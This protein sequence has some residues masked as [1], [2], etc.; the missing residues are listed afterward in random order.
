MA[1]KIESQLSENQI[2][3]DVSSYLGYITPFWTKRFRLISV[4]E[5]ATGADKLFDRF[6]PIYMQFKVSHGLNPMGKIQS[7]LAGKP[8][9]RIISYRKANNLSGNPILYF[10]L[11]KMAS[12]A[13]DYQHNI[14]HSLHHPPHQ[15]A[16][17][18][19][20]LALGV[21]EY[22]DLMNQDWYFRFIR[23]KPYWEKEIEVYDEAT[24]RKLLLGTNPF[25]RHHIS[26]PPHA[27]VNTHKHHYSYSKS[28]G[29]VAWHGGELLNDDFRLSTQ[30][31]RILTAFYFNE[32]VGI[33]R[34]QYMQFIRNFRFD[35][36][37]MISEDRS[38]NDSRSVILEFVR[39]LKVK[40]NI[41]V[42]FLTREESKR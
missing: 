10:Q 34:E 11:R 9:A 35:G 14:L 32:N 16:M 24:Q 42:L 39:S 28:G 3:A 2:E 1:F 27:I 33:N 13:R 40:Q 41:T 21:E 36:N 38:F 22:E 19:A 30:I 37:S 6:I 29:D 8:L 12:T 17:Y 15:F 5:Q 18:I 4:D 20:P 25:L 23:N 26:I 31:I 7:W